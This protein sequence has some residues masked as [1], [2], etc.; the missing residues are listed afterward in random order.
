MINLKKFLKNCSARVACKCGLA[1]FATVALIGWKSASI[2]TDL[3]SVTANPGEFSNKVITLSAPVVDNSVPEG[4]EYKTW[5]FV[6][7]SSG[8]RL[9]VYEEGFNP[10][11][12]VKAHSLV[13]KARLSGDEITVTGKF[14]E[15]ESGMI[16]KVASVRY[17]DTQI[18]TDEG[19]FVETVYRDD[20]YPGGPLFYDGHTYYPGNF[21]Y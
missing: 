17:G 19:P 4:R 18:N 14:E 1:L 20:C 11:T 6:L 10:A 9:A 3:S 12:I 16:L 2:E 5:N 21:P 8:S 13:E 15:R 7:G